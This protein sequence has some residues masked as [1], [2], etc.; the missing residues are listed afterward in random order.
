MITDPL[1]DGTARSRI[2]GD[3]S[4]LLS[5]HVVSI[6]EMLYGICLRYY[7]FAFSSP[8]QTCY[9]I[10]ITLIKVD[11]EMNSKNKRNSTVNNTQYQRMNL[12]YQ[13]AAKERPSIIRAY[14]A[15]RP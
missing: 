2:A 3:F 15:E 13:A 7:L 9:N 10:A 8:L 5:Y 6:S 4:S 12:T 11:E 1:L 14:S